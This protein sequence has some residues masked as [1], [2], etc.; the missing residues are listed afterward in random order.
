MLCPYCNKE[1]LWCENKE[2]YGRNYGQSYMCYLCKDCKAYVGCHNN[3]TKALGTMA[4]AELRNLRKE[5]H[6]NI[7]PYWK[8]KKMKRRD[9]YKKLSDIFGFDVH[10]GESDAGLCEKLIQVK[11]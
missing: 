5:A 3:T 1:A 10:V 11:L 2:I 4:N 6:K 7:D 8:S 9:V